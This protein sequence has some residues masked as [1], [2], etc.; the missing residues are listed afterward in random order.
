MPAIGLLFSQPDKAGTK[1]VHENFFVILFKILS[2]RDYLSPVIAPTMT[3]FPMF[4]D[5]GH[6][7]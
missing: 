2:L 1:K 6:A 3:D 7:S 4:D 5:N